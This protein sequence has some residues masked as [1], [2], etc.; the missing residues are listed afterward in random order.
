MTLSQ[1]TD[2]IVE[3]TQVVHLDGHVLDGRLPVIKELRYFDG[4]YRPWTLLEA[5]W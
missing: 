5:D 4:D 2:D 1:S 3:F